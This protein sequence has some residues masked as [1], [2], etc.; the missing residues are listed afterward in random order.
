[1]KSVDILN[2]WSGL[3]QEVPQ[4]KVEIVRFL[5]NVILGVDR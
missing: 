1:M 2:D 5:N 4:E 3:T